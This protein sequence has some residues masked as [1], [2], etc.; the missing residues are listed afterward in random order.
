M[1]FLL[2]TKGGYWNREEE[3]VMVLPI[4]PSEFHFRKFSANIGC[5]STKLYENHEYQKEIRMLS[6]SADWTLQL[7]P[8]IMK[9]RHYMFPRYFSKTTGKNLTKRKQSVPRGNAHILS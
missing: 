3:I 8:L 6:P 5:N 1:K 4:C 9:L 2:I 7:W